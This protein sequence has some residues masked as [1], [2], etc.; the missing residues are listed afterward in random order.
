MD[1]ERVMT[2]HTTRQGTFSQGSNLFGTQTGTPTP[3]GT[4]PRSGFPTATGPQL[5]GY[6]P[7]GAPIYVNVPSHGG[8]KHLKAEE[9]AKGGRRSVSDYTAFSNREGWSKWQR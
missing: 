1:D 6:T 8:T 4:N 9:F 2:R 3:Q 7:Q 5:A